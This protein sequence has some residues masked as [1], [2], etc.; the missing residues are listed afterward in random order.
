MILTALVFFVIAVFYASVGLGGGSSYLAIL[1]LAGVPYAVF[2]S[3]ALCCN[4][5]VTMQGTIQYMRKGLVRLRIL[6][7][8]CLSSIPLA[9]LGGRITVSENTFAGL[10]PLV[11][12]LAGIA[13]LIP[14]R[15]AAVEARTRSTAW[16]GGLVLGGSLGLLAGIVGIGGGI[17]LS[18]VMNLLRWAEPRQIA[19]TACIFIFL[20]SL[21][22]LA[23][24]LSKSALSLAEL[25]PYALLPL[26]VLVGGLLGNHFGAQ[27]MSQALVRRLT[28]ILVLVVA[29]RMWLHY[30]GR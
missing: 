5:V 22:G 23:G 24:Q 11:L 9:F 16:A 14:T 6:L 25:K 13:L 17:F 10:L 29:A 30:A 1:S 18:P 19:A 2:P 20:N 27:V 21:A 15:A 7:P 4:L 8:W 3:I 26:V 12:S 28:G